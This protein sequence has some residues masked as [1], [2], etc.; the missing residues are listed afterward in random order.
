MI[1]FIKIQNALD[2]PIIILYNIIMQRIH[3]TLA[4]VSFLFIFI[5]S[6]AGIGLGYESVYYRSQ[7]GDYSTYGSVLVG[8]V[9]DA[10]SAESSD[11]PITGI[12]S[13][14]RGVWVVDWEDGNRKTIH[15]IT[16]VTLDDF[17]KN[18]IFESISLIH[19]QVF[20]GKIGKYIT[21]ISSLLLVIISVTGFIRAVQ[22]QGGW[23]RLLQINRRDSLM[24]QLHTLG[25]IVVCVPII[26]LASTGFSTGVLYLLKY[27]PQMISVGDLESDP[28]KTFVGYA[29]MPLLQQ[30]QLQDVQ[31][32]V[33]PIYDDAYDIIS[34]QTSDKIL[35]LDRHDGTEV[36]SD[37]LST[38][39]KVVA[40]LR[41][42]HTTN[43]NLVWMFIWFVASVAI[44]VLVVTGGV[45]LIRRW[46]RQKYPKNGDII[47]LYAS[48]NGRTKLFV[49]ALYQAICQGMK[50]HTVGVR[51]L[52]DVH[53][54]PT[55]TK[56][57][58]IMTSTYG[59]GD[60]P[61]MAKGVLH[62]M[63][64]L[65]PQCPYAVIGFGDKS[66]AHF[67]GF[68]K[69]ISAALCDR[70]ADWLIEPAYI[71]NG[72]VVEFKDTVQKLG[73]AMGCALP[74]DTGLLI[75]KTDTYTV[76]HIQAYDN[77]YGKMVLIKLS[78]PAKS[79][80]ESGDIFGVV[81]E[82]STIRFYSIASS[83][84]TGEIILSVRVIGLVS[85]YLG[86]LQV[87]D[88]VQGFIRPNPAFHAPK[89][90]PLILL[91][92]GSGVAP[93]YGILSDRPKQTLQAFFGYTTPEGNPFSDLCG[94]NIHMAYSRVPADD[95][96]DIP[97]KTATYYQMRI[98][99]A[100]RQNKATI[101]TL[102]NNGAVIMMC[103]SKDMENSV[104]AALADSIDDKSILTDPKRL[105]KDTY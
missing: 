48:Q 99:D 70:G 46:D 43:Q 15:P 85:G 90:V 56:T 76:N 34:V 21:V 38:A 100:I 71:D 27:E 68:A 54:I 78:P 17:Q 63:A 59:D 102:I 57:I 35:Y 64:T 50:Q 61:D 44:C 45:I 101:N 73:D 19:T 49:R 75:P 86:A 14:A 42:L 69:N 60:A 65:Q 18:G 7:Y 55:S 12:F 92:I 88:E 95:Y 87:G 67:C 89:S 94:D 77:G 74:L 51:V 72:S 33:F 5:I 24:G 32:I 105:L 22:K 30:L 52:N 6:L 97:Q 81:F 53:K 36:G 96:M 62:K 39:G 9:M 29:N 79:T 104:L 16:G 91:G 1:F 58:I 10:V 84:H 82:Q 31:E 80:F 8:D 103:G 40:T 25:G 66:F 2:T 4:I 83:S 3:K 26:I 28:D 47:I 37:S 93:L 11:V 20:L 13:P 23:R 41:V 98:P